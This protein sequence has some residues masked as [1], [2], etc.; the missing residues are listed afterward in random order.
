MFKCSIS[1]WRISDSCSEACV[2]YCWAVTFPRIIFLQAKLAVSCILVVQTSGRWWSGLA[3]SVYSGSGGAVAAAPLAVASRASCVVVG[4]AG[5]Q[6]RLPPQLVT[7]TQLWWRWC[8]SLGYNF[9]LVSSDLTLQSPLRAPIYPECWS[10]HMI[11][12]AMSIKIM[13]FECLIE[14]VLAKHLMECYSSH[15]H[16][17]HHVCLDY[18]M[19]PG[20]HPCWFS[21]CK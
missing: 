2:L 21:M 11:E 1:F 17:L 3:W 12:K 7:V 19:Q 6:L 9:P 4:S 20:R 10:L 13:Y 5:P 14:H 15:T 18:L 16:F 8:L